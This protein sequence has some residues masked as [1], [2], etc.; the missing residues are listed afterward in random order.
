MAANTRNSGARRGIPWRIF[1]WG[2]AGLL[3]LLPFVANAPW[4]PADYIFAALL[5]GSVGL[6]LELI[7][8]KSSGLAY[9]TG[10]A[11]AVLA[12]FLT[13]WVNAA[14]GMIGS[15]DDPYNLLFLGVLGVALIG[16]VLARFAPAGMAR[17]MM[18]AALVQGLLS[19]VGLATD[20]RGGIFSMAF[21]GFWVLAA[22][23][24][25][26]A[27]RDRATAGA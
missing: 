15:E 20:V 9:R 8:R 12:A 3:L 11:V 17:A 24:F 6:A 1:G 25:H 26:N 4:T 27:A 19:A 18:S 10:A 2:G 23:L 22:A 13:I 7:F 14:V 16:A 21:I 5:F